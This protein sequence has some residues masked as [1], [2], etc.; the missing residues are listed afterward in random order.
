VAFGILQKEY[1]PTNRGFDSHYGYWNGAEDYF[2]KISGR[3]GLGFLCVL[4]VFIN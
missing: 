1:L 3:A 4:R 2:T